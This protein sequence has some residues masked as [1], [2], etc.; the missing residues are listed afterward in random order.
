MSDLATFRQWYLADEAK[1]VQ[2][3]LEAAAW[4]EG[5]LDR[6]SE[7]GRGLIDAIRAGEGVGLLD[8][9]LQE[10]ALSSEE[11]IALMCLAEAMMRVPDSD[12]LDELIYDK[13]GRAKWRSHVGKS[14]SFWVNA[15]TWGMLFT[16]KVVNFGREDEERF[17]NTLQRLM[18]NSSEPVIRNAVRQGI[19][20]MGKQFILGE[21]IETAMKRGKKM[22]ERGY[23]YS[24]DMLGEGA[25]TERDAERYYQSYLNA[26]E[27]I[28]MAQSQGNPIDNSGLSV[29]LSA[30]HP[31]YEV[32]T[33]DQC[34]PELIER[35]LELCKR[36]KKYNIGLTIDAEEAWRLEL[37]MDVIK[38]LCEDESLKDWQGLGLAVQAYQKRCPEL[39]DWLIALG[40]KHNRR[41]MV[42]LVKGAYWDSEIKWYQEQGLAGYPVFTR[43]DNT[44]VSYLACARKMLGAQDEIFPQFATH[45]AHTVAAI[46]AITAD[47]DLEFEL[48]RLHGMG[49]VLHAEVVEKGE[50]K[51][52]SRI[53][54]PVGTHKDL[55]SYL[56]RRLLENGANSSFVNHISNDEV[57]ADQL[58]TDPVAKVAA[59]DNVTNEHIPLPRDIYPT[60]TNSKGFD[61]TFP[62]VIEHFRNI[63]KE[64]PDWQ[65]ASLVVDY[66]PDMSQAKD[67]NSPADRNRRIGTVCEADE[68]LA[69]QAITAAEQGFSAW[70]QTSA[71]HRAALTRALA[72]QYEAHMDDWLRLCIFEAG[73]MWG[74]AV[75]EMREAVD[76]CRYYA[77]EIERI[78]AEGGMSAQGVWVCISPWNFPLAI[79]TGQIIAA[80]MA[81]NTVVAKPAGQ[82]P[83]IA[84]YAVSLMHEVGFPREA[85]QLVI[86]GP[87]IGA[88]LT[89]NPAICG[90]AFTGSTATAKIIQKS[91]MA[92]GQERTLIAETGGQNAMIVDSTALPEQVVDAVMMSAFQSAGQRCSALRVLCIQEDVYEETLS[93]IKGALRA[94]QIGDTV[95]NNID[96]GPLIDEA[97]RDKLEGYVQEH[98]EQVLIRH[99]GE[100]G[101]PQTGVFFAPTIIEIRDIKEMGDEQ[102]GPI[103]HVL[104]F[105]SGGI[106]KLVEGINNLGYGLTG[107]LH[108]RIEER[109]H[110]FAQHLHVGNIYVNRN[111]IGAI[112]GSQPFGG[113]GLSGTGPKAGGPQYVYR[114]MQADTPEYQGSGDT[115]ATLS[116][117]ITFD[118]AF[119]HAQSLARI[120][121]VKAAKQAPEIAEQLANSAKT[122]NLGNDE[123]FA[124]AIHA[125]SKT[126]A[127]LRTLV[128]MPGVTGENNEWRCYARGVILQMHEQPDTQALL[129]IVA[130]VLSGNSVLVTDLPQQWADWF[131]KAGIDEDVVQGISS[132]NVN[133]NHPGLSA[134][135][136]SGSKAWR[137]KQ[138]EQ[139]AQREGAILPC[140]TESPIRTGSQGI[141]ANPNVLAHLLFEQSISVNT[142]AAGGNIELLS[143]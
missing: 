41:F 122:L 40:Q 108:S 124:Q 107:C 136:L 37:S 48:Q 6:V 105:P 82:T 138:R 9:F 71:K 130:A 31:R 47:K 45:N 93:M 128:K 92:D 112:V 46:L 141:A 89:S 1:A 106:R 87:E 7:I 137:A 133:L 25:R 3:L 33:E 101:L 120:W 90:V 64:K 103:L 85:I 60:R 91:L 18:R 20:I 12:T 79:F 109:Q 139:W 143:L 51:V 50:R 29:K 97:A 84:H 21:T 78:D 2:R 5:E 26:L 62:P 24:F 94:R 72:D 98:A 83:I 116:S 16:G 134:L 59:L 35:M 80:L 11:G 113:H 38:A 73:K 42:R 114:F 10:Y 117:E 17:G 44:D 53:Y 104:K 66:Q 110:W 142:A 61:L 69:K 55:L 119:K 115:A 63:L 123:S 36:A 34:V 13:F 131:A 43:K 127:K 8:A 22:Q 32:M 67:V 14:D 140:L 30:I 15:A 95:A 125:L 102:F 58:L 57:S 4:Q 75:A 135:M 28:G 68:A 54:A 39:L 86:G 99:E 118:E 74:D 88:A 111:Q 65:A 52:P 96:V 27:A 56:V 129:Q 23:R 76:F 70:S 121:D 81:G 19:K 100:N 49:E 77:D 132:K 126:A